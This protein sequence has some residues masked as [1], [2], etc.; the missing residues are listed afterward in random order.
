MTSAI[1]GPARLRAALAERPDGAP[2]SQLGNN[3]TIVRRGSNR[4]LLA[5]VGCLSLLAIASPT[6]SAASTACNGSVKLCSRT[7]DKVVLPGSHNAMASKDVIPG[8]PNH[9]I[10]MK[11]QLKAGIRALLIDTHY[12]VPASTEIVLNG[13]PRTL[14]YIADANAS[15]PGASAYLCHASCS[16]GGTPLA[17]GLKVIADFLKLNRREVLVIVVEDYLRPTDFSAA[18]TASGL[19][20][21]VYTGS[22][23][24]M[25]TLSSMIS[26][27]QRVLMVSEGTDGSLAWYRNGY[28]G[29]MQETPYSFATTDLLTDPSKLAASCVPY[30]GGTTGK[31]F[32]MNH[33]VTPPGIGITKPADSAIVNT[34]SAIL[35]RANAC[36]ASRGRL[37][38]MIA[39]NNVELGSVVSAAK[40]LNGV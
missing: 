15:T 32:L 33:F 34:K 1:H 39:V 40:S 27:D 13:I 23:S 31:L 21:Y 7:L 8:L 36:K 24:T 3:G 19:R 28:A 29:L 17:T 9:V 14:R 35:A 37:P 11:D 16:Y 12:G 4:I 10:P 38:S 25:P 30:R 2:V 18:V 20:P 26:K 22:V 6:A 5:A